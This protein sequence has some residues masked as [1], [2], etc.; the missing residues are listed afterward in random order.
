MAYSNYLISPHE[1]MNS[2]L[3]V[4]FIRYQGQN[5][6]HLANFVLLFILS[7]MLSAQSKIT[8]IQEV[9]H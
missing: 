4:W 2:S 3:I 1:T 5:Y 7:V 9:L 6:G 8:D